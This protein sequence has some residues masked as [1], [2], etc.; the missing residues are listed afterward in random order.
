MFIIAGFGAAGMMAAISASTWLDCEN[1]KLLSSN[2]KF[3]HELQCYGA[4][5]W[6]IGTSVWKKLAYVLGNSIAIIIPIFS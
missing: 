3:T 5:H 2:K 1:F 4:A 6:L